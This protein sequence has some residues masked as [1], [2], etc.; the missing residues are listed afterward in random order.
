MTVQAPHSC[1]KCPARWSGAKFCHCRAC[2]RTFTTPANFDRHLTGKPDRPV[3]N[4]VTQG[5]VELRPGVWGTPGAE[6]G[7]DFYRSPRKG[8]L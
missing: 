8:H 2:H 5:L 1:G 4:S 7:S 3:C 6:S